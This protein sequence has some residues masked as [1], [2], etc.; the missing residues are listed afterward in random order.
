MKELITKIDE[1]ID[2]TNNLTREID[3]YLKHPNDYMK[4][5]IYDH[6][7]NGKTWGIR[8]YRRKS[9]HIIFRTK[10]S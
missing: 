2:H 7:L 5:Y 4:T 6:S 3:T 9:T 8:I 1:Y 10:I